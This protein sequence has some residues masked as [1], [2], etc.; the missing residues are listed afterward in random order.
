MVWTPK[1][2]FVS[3]LNLYRKGII[4]LTNGATE[5]SGT[6]YAYKCDDCKKVLIDYSKPK[7][8]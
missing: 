4:D 1:A 3:A 8:K 5:Y 2:R 6:V 7:N